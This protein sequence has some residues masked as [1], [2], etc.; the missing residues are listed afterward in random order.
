MPPGMPAHGMLRNLEF[1]G[2][3]PAAVTPHD[4]VARD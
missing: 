3:L 1:L 2:D 4:A